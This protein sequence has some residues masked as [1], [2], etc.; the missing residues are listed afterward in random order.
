MSAVFKYIKINGHVSAVIDYINH[1][2]MEYNIG[3]TVQEHPLTDADLGLSI[4]SLME[5]FPLDRP[6]PRPAPQTPTELVTD[7]STE[8]SPRS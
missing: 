2:H 5:R 3:E 8:T 7:L 1:K 6:V 4:N